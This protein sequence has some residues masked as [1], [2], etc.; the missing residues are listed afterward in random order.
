MGVIHLAIDYSENG[1]ARSGE[2]WGI[3]HHRRDAPDATCYV[4]YSF[5]LPSRLRFLLLCTSRGCYV[6]PP[7]RP[8][9]R[10]LLA[11]IGTHNFIRMVSMITIVA[12][13]T[14]ACSLGHFTLVMH[15]PR[16]LYSSTRTRGPLVLLGLRRGTSPNSMQ[17]LPRVQTSL[18]SLRTSTSES[19]GT[20]SAVS[21]GTQ[22]A[23][24]SLPYTFVTQSS[25]SS[26]GTLRPLPTL[27]LLPLFS[28]AALPLLSLQNP[29]IALGFL[30]HPPVCLYSRVFVISVL[31]SH[32]DS[33]RS[34]KG[35]NSLRTRRDTMRR[36]R[37]Q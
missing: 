9:L 32:W 34:G 8:A 31:F 10:F 2:V 25:S 28:F 17:S 12:Y 27:R 33:T 20:L 24:P 1:G 26:I 30:I 16:E 23:S 22:D 14:D 36:S 7:R 11:A 15:A 19:S 21:A 4:L 18:S 37:D 6:W 13:H 3:S 5:D 29:Y 35:R